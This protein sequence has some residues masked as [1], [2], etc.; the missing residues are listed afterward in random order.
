MLLLLF[1]GLLFF[2]SDAYVAAKILYV[3]LMAN[4]LVSTLQ[5]L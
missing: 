2:T 3:S 4:V 5:F 1:S